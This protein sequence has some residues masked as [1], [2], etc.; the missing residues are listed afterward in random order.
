MNETNRCLQRN[1]KVS[2]GEANNTMDI[3]NNNN[4]SSNNNINKIKELIRG[5]KSMN[6]KCEDNAKNK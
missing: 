1:R 3:N 4:N 2:K 6:K 5:L